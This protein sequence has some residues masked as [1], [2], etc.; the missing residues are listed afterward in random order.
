[1]AA[2]SAACLNTQ[3]FYYAPVETTF[4]IRS[5]LRMDSARREWLAEVGLVFAFNPPPKLQVA[6]F[7]FVGAMAAA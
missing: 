1:L 2:T 4:S 5:I 7:R 6:R 3:R